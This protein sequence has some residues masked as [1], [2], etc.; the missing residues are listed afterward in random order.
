MFGSIEFDTG[1]IWYERKKQYGEMVDGAKLFRHKQ[2]S[3]A[4]NKAW[5]IQWRAGGMV[6]STGM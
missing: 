1:E 5:S 4:E 2:M 3:S 6:S